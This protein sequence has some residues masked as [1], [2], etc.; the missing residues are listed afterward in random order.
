[1]KYLIVDTCVWYA[2]FDERDDKHK[3]A[4]NIQKWI[5]YP[6]LI[7]PFPSLYETLNTRFTR[8]KYHQMEGLFSLLENHDKVKLVYDDSY[9]EQAYQQLLEKSKSKSHY[10]LVDAIIRLIANDNSI[11]VMDILTFNISD[12]IGIHEGRSEVITPLWDPDSYK[13]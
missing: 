11:P 5:K 1:M 13:G 3:Y 6:K 4:D 12:F 2:L 10:S 7:I 8:N 9:R